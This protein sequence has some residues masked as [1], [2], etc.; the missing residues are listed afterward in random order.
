MAESYFDWT[1][2]VFDPSA[3]HDKPEALKGIRVLELCTLILGPA[4]TDFLM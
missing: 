1:E 3:V 4:T 2:R